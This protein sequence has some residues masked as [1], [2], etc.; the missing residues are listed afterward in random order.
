M[1]TPVLENIPPELKA[2]PQ[3]V[4]W[5]LEER[6]G[7]ATKVPKNPKT[8]GNAKA[9]DP[10][11]WGK[12]AQAVRHWEAHK[13]NGVA[14]I[15]YEFSFYDPYCGVDLDKCRDPETG[16]IKSWA[17]DIIAQLN[18]YTEISPSGQGIHVL[19]K[20]KL[21]PEGLRK[22]QVEMYC[23]GRYFTMTG[24]HLEETPTSIEDRQAE[25]TALHVAVF[26]QE[27]KEASRSPSPDSTMDLADAEL[28]D[29]AHKAANGEKFGKLWRGDWSEYPSQSE[30]DLALCSMLSF[31]TGPDPAMIDRLLRQSGLYRKGKWDRPTAGSTYGAI[32]INKA[33]SQATEYYTP[34]LDPTPKGRD[35]AKKDQEQASEALKPAV[36]RTIT[37]KALAAK[38][39]PPRRWAIPRL[40]TEGLTILAGPPKV[41]KSWLALNM[42]VAVAGGGMVLGKI[43][44]EQGEV[45]YLAL[46]D[47]ERR[48]KERLKKITPVGEPPEALSIATAGDF[49]P[50]DKGG[51]VAL[52]EWLKKYPRA[53]LV[54][55]DTL[56]RVKPGRSRNQDSY[57]HDSAIISTLQKLSIDHQVALVVIH[58]T[59]K[60]EAED[61]VAEVS[62]TF[63]LTGAADCVAVLSR[64][65]RGQMDGSLKLTGRDIE[66]Q[67]LAL[68]FDPNLGLWELLGEASQY[69]R[70][71]ERQDILLI[72][73]EK[74][75]QTPAQLADMLGKKRGAIRQLLR[76]MKEAG[77]VKPI[78]GN[79]YETVKKW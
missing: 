9:N 22:G 73:R 34:G 51:L 26:S 48:L 49:P 64:K 30:A 47:S 68:K 37:A 38:D 17:K 20:G 76:K 32:T 55:I 44:V 62:G 56:A 1:L 11:T 53:K 60:Q 72:L 65:G 25:L 21:P 8:G 42:A 54:I 35:T 69:A 41:C 27:K 78:S 36:L 63:G 77:E 5:S 59:K 16:E 66:E 79:R 29:R 52:A 13:N 61:F 46:E 24:L 45:L 7:K 43:P 70:S 40:I 3:W 74:G 18:S 33:L 2:R 39:F 23:F 12:F 67:E 75:P 15:G 28:L 50:L 71:Q 14:G 58:H 57:S 10:E 31:W 4:C 6:D 19:V